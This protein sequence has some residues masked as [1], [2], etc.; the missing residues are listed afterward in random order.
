MDFID[1][2]SAQISVLRRL[3]QLQQQQ[4]AAAG[5]SPVFSK[6]AEA[7]IYILATN[8]LLY[9]AL[10]IIVTLV[11]K[12]YFPESLDRSRAGPPSSRALAR[13]YSYRRAIEEQAQQ[14]S[15]EHI[16]DSGDDEDFLRRQGDDDE[17][18]DDEIQ[19]LLMENEGTRN[20]LEFDQERTSKSQVLRRLLLCCFMLNL[21]FV[22]WGALQER[23]LTRRYPR[24][25]GEYFVYSYAVS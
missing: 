5:Q 21:T 10:I 12:I 4:P 19:D 16:L 2:A 23:M 11:A 17:D 22:T 24:K 13:S 15:S 25:T 8:F 14:S 6:S 18:D 7:E 3:D 1:L 20:V 9:V